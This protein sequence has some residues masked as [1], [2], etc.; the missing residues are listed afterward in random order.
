MGTRG[1][2]AARCSTPPAHGGGGAGGI[3]PSHHRSDLLSRDGAV[4]TTVRMCANNTVCT[5]YT[6]S[7]LEGAAGSDAESIRNVP[8]TASVLVAFKI[9]GDPNVPSGRLTFATELPE[10]IV[11]LR[12]VKHGV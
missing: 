11:G 5:I 8:D 3:F 9:T 2:T 7:H 1:I 4:H 12:Q 6:T 10:S